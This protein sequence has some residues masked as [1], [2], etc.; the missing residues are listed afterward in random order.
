MKEFASVSVAVE[1]SPIILDFFN[2]LYN[3]NIRR[4]EITMTAM[5][6]RYILICFAI[7]IIS[8]LRVINVFEVDVKM[9]IS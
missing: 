4:R 9:F 6:I 7:F 8:T 1:G 3:E 2:T 5:E